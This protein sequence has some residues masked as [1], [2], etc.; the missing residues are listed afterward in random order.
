MSALEKAV[1]VSPYEYIRS[2]R[3]AEEKRD[4]LNGQIVAMAG[5]TYNHNMIQRNVTRRLATALEGRP[6]V[7]FTSDMKVRIEKANQFRYPDAFALCGDIDFFDE[8]KDAVCNPQMI[9]EVLSP[10]TEKTDRT[11]KFA[12]YRL[13]DSFSEYLLLSQGKVEAELYQKD[14]S[15]SW[16]GESFEDADTVIHLKSIDVSLRLGDLYDKVDFSDAG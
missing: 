1:F 3:K 10:S 8:T 15:G 7:D 9:V 11:D 13:I 2:E 16:K 6:C 4:Y 5:G 12:M 14:E